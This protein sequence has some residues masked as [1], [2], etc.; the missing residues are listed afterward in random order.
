MFTGDLM[1]G[2]RFFDALVDFAMRWT[3]L[4]L[5]CCIAIGAVIRWFLCQGELSRFFNP[6]A[7][8]FA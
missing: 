5:G 2:N 6:L 1:S 3:R 8:F 4:Y 7:P